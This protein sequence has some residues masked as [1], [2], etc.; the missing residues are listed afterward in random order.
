MNYVDEFR[1]PQR[2]RRLI[3]AIHELYPAVG[4]PLQLMEFCGGHTHTLLRYGIEQ[5]L[6]EGIEMVHGPGCPV[7]VLPRERVDDA[8][9]LAERPEVIFAT[10]GD[11][12]RVPGS[13]QTLLQA[14]AGGAD[15]RMVYSPLDALALARRHPEREVVFFA[16]GF[17]TT[18]PATALT[19]LQAARQQIDNF[20]LFCNHVTT[21][22]TLRAV[23]DDPDMRLDGLLAPGHVSMVVGMQPFVWVADHYQLPIAITGFEPLDMLQS[24]WLLLRQLAAGRHEVENQYARVVPAAGNAAGLDAMARVFDLQVAF[25][26]DGSVPPGGSGVRMQAEYA[27]FDAARRF[28]VPEPQASPTT[29][30]CELVLMGRIQPQACRHFG[31]GCT[32]ATP[33]GALMVSA[34]GACAACYRYGGRERRA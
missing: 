29:P 6:P 22:P 4:R 10:F 20:S 31:S 3:A 7:C 30:E 14:R 9:V 1:D 26:W 28:S 17:E 19:V 18:M 34:E 23:L 11:A 25:T 15:V 24:L 21:L 32:P 27:R 8:V 16:L 5:L 12:L 2:A 33:M 13:R